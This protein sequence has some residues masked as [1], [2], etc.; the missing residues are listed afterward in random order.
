MSR[1]WL[2]ALRELFTHDRHDAD[3]DREL[4]SHLDEEAEARIADGMPPDEARFAARRA[5]G[6]VTAIR[7]R[8]RDAWTWGRVAHA[9]RDLVSSPR[10][11]LR[12]ALRTLTKQPGFTAAA[13]VGLGLGIGA[14][15]T[16]YSVIHGVLLDP[17]P[18]YRE[19]DRIVGF[20]VVD[21]AGGRPGGRGAF[22]TAEFLDY[23]AQATSFS[24]TIAGGGDDVLWRTPQGT[25]QWVGGFTSGNTF[26]FMGAGAAIGR[27]LTIEDEQPGA[28]PVFVMGHKLWTTRFGQDPSV[29]N[30]VFT[31]N[32]TPTTLVGV[33]PER[34]SKLGADVWLPQRLDRA[35]RT[36]AHRFWRFQARLKPGVSVADAEAELNAIARRIAPNYPR[37]YP[38]RFAI[39]VETIIDGIVGQFR[40]T[41]YMMAAA[42]GMLLLI[43]C[44]NVANMLL[45]RAADREQEMAVR[46]S[47]GA[48]RLRL[49][50][51]LMIES[52]LL[53]VAGAGLGCLIAYGGTALVSRSMPDGLIPRESVIRLDPQVLLF[54]L[55]VAAATAIVFGLVPALQTARRQLVPALRDGGKGTGGGFRRARLSHALVIGEIALALVLLSSAGLLMR[56]FIKMQASDLGF[57]PEQVLVVRIPGNPTPRTLDEQHAL[58]TQALARVRALPGVVGAT[59]SNGVPPFGGFTLAFD[60]PGASAERRRSASVEMVSDD[61][62]RTLRIR[63]LRGRV[64]TADDV[65]GRRAVAVVNERLASQHFPGVDPIGRSVA[66]R[67]PGVPETTPPSAFQ[68]VGIIADARNRSLPDPIVAG[69][70]LPTSVE[71]V[72]FSLLIRT[73][74]PP[75]AM[76]ETI[77]RELWAQDRSL[78]LAD[79]GAISDYIQRF[80]Y[81][82]PRL[83]LVVFGSFA[84]VGLLLVVLGVASLVAYTV[85]RQAREIGIRL[86]IGASR[87]DVLRLTVGMGVRW[88]AY[89]VG[90][91]L[92]GSLA[93]TR[94]LAAELWQVSARDPLT[95]SIGVAVIAASATLASY[96]P[97]RR[98]TRIDPL[99]VLR[100]Q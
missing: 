88:L 8:S 35:D 71:A 89:G 29:V 98:A 73:A 62:F 32:G 95:L 13:V 55:V 19:V 47:L 3:V 72:R 41:L 5:L 40:T 14:S 42:V 38:E 78:A 4:R 46:A 66:L 92:L 18:M 21:L 65:A 80:Q 84:A 2:T 28:P 54:S 43:A 94:L 15:T 10:Q 56:S 6:N 22:Q 16:I 63:L 61:Y 82:R 58:L 75:M 36:V 53:A 77:K 70:Y 11:D 74:G 34:I 31:L 91:G 50:R 60:V 87:A 7:E 86:A 33:M 97:A 76:A 69:V 67:L 79:T 24:E 37:L 51:Q 100:S 81:A 17:Y 93:T 30:R 68:I 83:G 90:L 44:I 57:D 12:Y 23:K 27:T 64:I 52:L 39:R 59:S 99:V 1:R 26:S 25:E 9:L 85:A 96:L 49:V 45:S 48:S 20:S